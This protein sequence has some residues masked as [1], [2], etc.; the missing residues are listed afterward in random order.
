MAINTK[1]N[2][3]LNFKMKKENK[4][5]LDKIAKENCRSVSNLI[6]WVL[7]NYIEEYKK[8][9]QEQEQEQK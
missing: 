2:S 1:L 7:T 3:R 4:I 5:L 6:E 8:Q 9:E